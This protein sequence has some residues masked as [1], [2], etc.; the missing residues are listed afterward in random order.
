MRRSLLIAAVIAIA[1]ALA[2]P[3]GALSL[4]SL[5]PPPKAAVSV[6][7]PMGGLAFS[8]ECGGLLQI[9]FEN[10]VLGC[11]HGPDLKPD[12]I[13]AAAAASY[14]TTYP[15]GSPVPAV[16]CIGDGVSGPRVEVIYAV[17]LLPNTNTSGATGQ[18]LNTTSGVVAA[19]TPSLSTVTNRLP[20]DKYDERLNALRT[21]FAN[22][23]DRVNQS[24]AVNGGAR[25]LR[26][27]TD[28]NCDV[29]INR[30]N[31]T[32]AGDDTFSNTIT[33]LQALGF[34]K[35]NRKYMVFVE[36]SVLCGI[37]TVQVDDVPGPENRNNG[38]IAQY[39]R[40]DTAAGGCFEGGRVATHELFHTFGAV[41]RTAPHATAAGHCYDGAELMC[42]NDDGGDSTVKLPNGTQQPFLSSCPADYKDRLDC[43]QDD[44]FNVAPSSSNYLATHWNT[45]QSAFLQKD[46]SD[47]PQTVSFTAGSGQLTFSW[48]APAND[49]GSL[50][51]GF[52]AKLFVAGAQVQAKAV[53]GRSV[54]FTGLTNGTTYQVQVRA[55]NGAGL[56]LP[57]IGTGVPGALAASVAA[58]RF[59]TDPFVATFNGPV[60]NVS[61]SN[62]VVSAAGAGS[63]A[64]GTSV[65]CTDAALVSVACSSTQVRRAVLTV[66]GLVPG[67]KYTATINPSG[68]AAITAAT[69]G[70][71]VPTLTTP[72]TN[73][74]D[75]SEAAPTN[76]TWASVADTT[77]SGGSYNA[78]AT[79][80]ATA[81]FSFTGTSVTWNSF[82]GPDQGIAGIT[83]DNGPETF[84]DLYSATR[85][86][87]AT[88]ISLSNG[89]HKLTIRVTGTK[90]AASTGTTV[91]LDGVGV[92]GSPVSAPPIVYRWAT[93]A[94]SA[95]DDNGIVAL[96]S[97]LG[98]SSMTAG[99]T[100]S[101]LY[102]D[103]DYIRAFV[104][105]GPDQGQ[106]KVTVDGA[107]VV[108]DLYNPTPLLYAITIYTQN[109]DPTHTATIEVLNAK[110]PS[111]SGYGVTFDFW[112][113]GNF[114]A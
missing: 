32:P 64:A 46:L 21:V 53:T 45:A 95:S 112:R 91:A 54:T 92:N 3:A 30:V 71:S 105:K 58:G 61:T 1:A 101:I 97:P 93:A 69:G 60:A 5:A 73:I 79:T 44:Y 12:G 76:F 111:S 22:M 98:G 107:S 43:N 63:P 80:G 26:F 84:A 15:A 56:S 29:V 104:L 82:K 42:Y 19:L 51:T 33:E 4:L 77:A 18:V 103:A 62:F 110:N 67:E 109:F 78:D 108:H 17:P 11:T 85:T 49:R 89:P 47:P 66:P 2:V 6:P 16:P 90:N 81:T 68:A 13:D 96:T 31:F 52:S 9:R 35:A 88:T 20:N 74:W 87:S 38:S 28:A 100:A 70:A 75:A 37:G 50:V 94:N 39:A 114:Q 99:P 102:R 34:N 55:K 25:H 65:A 72:A 113:V 7:N 36:S 40:V 83:I 106:V 59:V 8:K 57:A 24:A 48:L 41:S 27:V 23:N 10:K 86:P 14:P